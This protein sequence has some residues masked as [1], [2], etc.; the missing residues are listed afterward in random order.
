M[1]GPE[2]AF[3][4]DCIQSS[5][6]NFKNQPTLSAQ[7]S[8]PLSHQHHSMSEI[9]RPSRVTNSASDQFAMEAG[10]FRLSQGSRCSV[11]A[12][13]GSVSPLQDSSSNLTS[14]Q[15]EQNSPESATNE[16]FP[17][18]SF[19]SASS[20]L[21]DSPG[22]GGGNSGNLISQEVALNRP[23]AIFG[24]QRLQPMVANRRS[25]GPCQSVSG[26]SRLHS[27]PCRFGSHRP[28]TGASLGS[29]STLVSNSLP[30]S[31]SLNNFK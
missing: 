24:E 14:P 1:M 15:S 21:V 30:Y 12:Q 19:K 31:S 2:G 16:Y 3:Q 28:T 18:P 22:G 11:G 17:Y 4:A 20:N 13:H 27:Q 29:S 10:R 25:I 8:Q 9:Q 26:A 7:Q 23:T 6:P 5:V